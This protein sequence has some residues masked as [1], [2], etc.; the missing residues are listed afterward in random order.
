M[1]GVNGVA[2][3]VTGAIVQA[4]AWT[5]VANAQSSLLIRFKTQTNSPRF[6]NLSDN[7]SIEKTTSKGRCP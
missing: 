6:T 1:N 2:I 7:K 4:F 3:V 5:F